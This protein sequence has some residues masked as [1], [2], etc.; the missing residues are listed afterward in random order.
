LAFVLLVIGPDLNGPGI[1]SMS[2]AENR[3][4]PFGLLL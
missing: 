1:R 4:T 3:F 2:S